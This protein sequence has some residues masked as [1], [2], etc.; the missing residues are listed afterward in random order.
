GFFVFTLYPVLA[1]LYYSFCDYDVLARPVWIGALNYRD[2]VT[3][4][5]YWKALSNTLVFSLISLPLGLTVALAL[6]LLLN[7]P[8]RGR[9]IFRAIYYLPS[10]LPAVASAT[11]WLWVLNGRHGLLNQALLAIGIDHPPQWLSDPAWTKPAL[12]LMAVWGCGNT[13]L[14]FLAALQGVPRALLEAAMIDGASPWRRLWHV[15]LPAVSPVIY[16][17]LII[18][19]IGSLQTF[20]TAF[21]LLANGGPD[22]SALFYAVYLYQNAFEYRQMGY[23][24][25]MAWVLFLITLGLTWLAMR[26]TRGFVHYQEE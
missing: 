4:H 19:L 16:F 7:R 23:A 1:S 24:C 17:N 3:D 15:I 12:A 21:V 14:I 20:A 26:G 18:G 10:L 2:M 5:V 9:G 13:V 25:A 22:R 11:V 8:V 6:A